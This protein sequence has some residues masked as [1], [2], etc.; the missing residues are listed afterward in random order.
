[1]SE[2][3]FSVWVFLPD[4]THFPVEEGVDA[5]RAVQVAKRTASLAMQLPGAQQAALRIIITDGGDHTVFQWE[6][7][8][9]VKWPKAAAGNGPRTERGSS[10][11]RTIGS[12][13]QNLPALL[14][15]CSVRD[16]AAG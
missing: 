7:G 11:S 13:S 12:S 3:E 4:E 9:G 8:T 14:G 5:E 6:R 10:S 2:G 1:M 15:S 16:P